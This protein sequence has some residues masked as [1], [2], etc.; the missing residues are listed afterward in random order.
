M[1]AINE[2]LRRQRRELRRRL[3]AS[4]RQ[5]QAPPARSPTPTPQHQ[6]ATAASPSS[7]AQSRSG[8]H[9]EPASQSRSFN[10]LLAR[11]GGQ[12]GLAY[13]PVGR[14]S[15][16]RTLGDLPGGVAWST[17]KVPLALAVVQQ[18]RG[19]PP[20]KVAEL[21]RLAI[22]VSDNE[23][24]MK[25]WRHLGP[26]A[27]AAAKVDAVLRD[28]ADPTTIVQSQDVRPPYTPFGQTWWSIGD[29]ARFAALLPCLP[30]S[31]PVLRLMGRV[32]PSQRWG[33]GVLPSAAGYKGGWGPGT[34]G[35]YLVRQL[36]LIRLGTGEEVGVAMASLPA[37]GSYQMGTENLSIIAE[38]AANH[39]RDS[40][41]AGC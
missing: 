11:I 8:L 38:W 31:G 37:D 32:T 22:E 26:P 15:Q 17:I 23:A 29:Q 13:A 12:A 36:A 41:P 30:E 28:G 35:R 2:G 14:P 4:P 25:L 20:G 34:D 10:S 33:A 5:Q 3:V 16:L 27:T 39:I 9:P 18:D 24:A 6:T 1:T 40:G 7:T 19:A 21:M